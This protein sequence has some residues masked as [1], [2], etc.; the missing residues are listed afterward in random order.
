MWSL[1]SRVLGPLFER[2]AIRE[3]G[4]EILQKYGMSFLRNFVKKVGPDTLKNLSKDEIINL[5]KEE[6]Q[7]QSGRL[8]ND[9]SRSWA[10]KLA[11][12]SNRKIDTI[13][14]MTREY[15]EKRSLRIMNQRMQDTLGDQ[16]LFKAA[17]L[18]YTQYAKESKKHGKLYNKAR[19]LGS[20]TLESFLFPQ[21][22]RQAF[23]G[24]FLRGLSG[25][26]L[27]RA[28]NRLIEVVLGIPQVAIQ[29][30]KYRVFYRTLMKEVKYLQ[31]IG[32]VK[33]ATKL[34]NAIKY[35]YKISDQNVAGVP[36]H[37]L[38]YSIGGRVTGRAAT[39]L[40]INF[41][42]VSS[43]ERHKRVQKFKRSITPFAKQRVKIYIKG[44]TK[45]NGT[46]VKGHYRQVAVA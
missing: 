1:L 19:G 39:A 26:S 29:S 10:K 44:Y 15:V 25:E 4:T 7:N 32:D 27:S 6:F 33:S 5:A 28:L 8:F 35:A 18:P 21:T 34:Y 24:G 14:K 20:D 40:G 43:D 38:R 2:Y 30:P 22:K 12:A 11:G 23:T 36:E 9:T 16:N 17:N 46:K 3:A 37:M 13:E 31:D 42:F 41:V 45:D